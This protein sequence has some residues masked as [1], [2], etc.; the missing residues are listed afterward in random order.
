MVGK[1]SEGLSATAVIDR[2]EQS[3]YPTGYLIYHLICSPIRQRV[4]KI[5][6]IIPD[7]ILE[8]LR[9]LTKAKNLT[10]GLTVAL[11]EWIAMKKIRALNR[12]TE[13][14]PLRFAKGFSAE[15]MRSLNRRK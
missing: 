6:A 9:S 4:M 11:R 5:T 3:R 1:K 2:R 10:E 15:K 14:A 8:N 12:R 13:Q 7:E